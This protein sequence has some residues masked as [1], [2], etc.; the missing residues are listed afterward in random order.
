MKGLI[1]KDFYL[2]KSYGKQYVLIFGAMIIY[3]LFMRSSSFAMIYF[4]LMGSTVVLSSMSMDEAVSFHKFAL[5]MPV[6]LSTII[7]SKYILFLIT[8]GIGTAVSI[9]MELV[10]TFVSSDARIWISFGREE[11]AATVTVF[12]LAN[13]IS[14]PFMFKLGV[15]KARYIN[16]CSMLAVGGFLVIS[17][18]MGDKIGLSIGRLDEILSSN[19]F[20]GLCIAIGVISLTVSYLV[21]VKIAENKEW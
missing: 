12:V 4:V 11:F 9:L 2:L 13:A 21:A 8:I 20:V 5:T 16:I 6:N 1:L 10:L 7:K 14:I 19:E 3:A 18:T 17:A 15:E